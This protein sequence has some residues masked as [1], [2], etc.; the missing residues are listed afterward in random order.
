M[1]RETVIEVHD[2]KKKFKVYRDKGN[3]LKERVLF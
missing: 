2:L 1:D 3:T